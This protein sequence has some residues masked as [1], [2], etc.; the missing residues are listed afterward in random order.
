MQCSGIL[1]FKSSAYTS[2]NSVNVA[3]T[4]EL[5]TV[6]SPK[7]VLVKTINPHTEMLSSHENFIPERNDD[8]G[9]TLIP[10][11]FEKMGTMNMYGDYLQQQVS[12]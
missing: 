8:G 2:H 1:G 12:S 11:H 3:D 6:S 7:A 5:S 10:L 9:I 4:L